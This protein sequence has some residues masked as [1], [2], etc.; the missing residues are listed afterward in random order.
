MKS[1]LLV[2]VCY[3]FAFI[4]QAQAPANHKLND[5]IQLIDAWIEAQQAYDK[6]PGLSV[7]IV[8]DQ[9]LIW[10]RGYGF[11][12]VKKNLAATPA[13]IYSICS[14]SKFFTS[15]AIM[16]LY[17]QGKLRLDD[18]VSAHLPSFKIQ[19]QYKESGPITIRGLLTHSSGLPREADFPYWTGPDFKF[20]SE[21]QVADKVQKQK[22]LYPASTY[23]QYS[24]LGMTIL[25]QIVEKV[26]GQPYDVYVEENILRPLRLGNTHPYLPASEFGNK[27][28]VGYSSLKRDGT[29]EML[30]IFDPK[31]I[32]T[33]VGYSST[34]EDLA[35]F[36][37]WQFRLLGNGGKE[38]LKSST[39]KEMQR[40]HFTDPDWRMQWGLGFA[41][42]PQN[43]K[44]LVG[45]SG[46]CPGYRTTLLIDPEEKFAYIVMLNSM[47]NPH[48]LAIQMRNIILKGQTENASEGS[49]VNLEAY[50]G[51]YNAQPWSSEKRIISWYGY[52]AIVD[53]PSTTPLEDM[54]LLYHV[55][56]DTFRRIRR[57]ETLGEEFTFERN[58]TTG[59]VQ[60]MWF[61][62][63]FAEK[64]K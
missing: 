45:L 23:I 25:G 40:V 6:I 14:M 16:Q 38:I 2:L 41:V 44:T 13:T 59:K 5:A 9:Q 8:K 33:A 30:P 64:I 53:L 21:Q 10:S 56:D 19:Q 37:S 24:N 52:L 43:G 17:D 61:H 22:T 4:S 27:M 60:R 62:S 11:S 36:A 31:G 26:S 35:G 12:N 42:W 63:N 48:L 32:K 18:S 47:E 57:D 49:K 29:R 51:L 7:G 34:V 20:P 3:L 39:L 50:T 1:T 15:V 28:A 54:T 58:P 55:K 46:R